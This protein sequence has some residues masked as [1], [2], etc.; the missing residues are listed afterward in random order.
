VVVFTWQ[1]LLG[2]L[3]TKGN[4]FKRGI[5]FDTQQMDCLWCPSII[6]SE[7]RL[8]GTCPFACGLWYK[9]YKW[10]GFS[11]VVHPDSFVFMGMFCLAGGCGKGLKWLLTV[12]HAMMWTIWRARNE[13]IFS[14][15]VP[16][17]EEC[18]DTIK[19]TSWKWLVGKEKGGICIYYE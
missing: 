5:F 12:W 18:F 3:S 11:S 19:R 2:R 9:L 8:F 15:K 13:F 4:L 17:L 14:S 10:F 6:E 1:L 7:S 16:L